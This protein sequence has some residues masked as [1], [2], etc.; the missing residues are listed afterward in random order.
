MSALREKQSRFVR[1]VGRLITFSVNAGYDLTFGECYRTPQQA[2]WNAEHG[3]GIANSLHTERLA[4]D[5]NLFRNGD[6]VTGVSDYQP[7]G[8]FW[9]SLSTDCAWGGRFAKPD[10]YHFSIAHDGRR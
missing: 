6:L 8:E 5:L 9:E 7:L 1:Y 10:Q 2:Q 3:L 4:I